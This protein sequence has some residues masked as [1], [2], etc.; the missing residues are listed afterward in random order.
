MSFR[1]SQ[2]SK[3]FGLGLRTEHYQDFLS[4]PQPVDWLE[5]ISDN[6]LVAG[7]KPLV[8]LDQLRR[9]YPMVM[10]GVAMSIGA[11]K[12]LD[13]D[14]LTR[15][16]RLAQRVEPLWI[17]DHLCWIGPGPEQLHDL[18]PLPYTDEAARRVIDHIRQVQDLLGRRFVLENVSSYIDYKASVQSEWQFLSHVAQEADCLLLLDVNNVYVSS[19]NHGFDPME[20]LRALPAGRI[21]QIHLAGHSPAKGPGHPV[22]DTHDHPVAPEVWALFEQARL[23]FGPVATMIERDA[24]IP[25]LDVLLDELTLAR[26]HARKADALV[27]EQDLSDGRLAEAS[28]ATADSDLTLQT[29]Q[30]RISHYVLSPASEVEQGEVQTLLRTPDGMDP[31]HRI[32]AYHHAYRARLTEV[33]ADTFAKTY[34]F[35]GSD[36]FDAE[37]MRFAPLNPPLQRSLNRYGEGFPDYLAARY[38]GHPELIELA[39]L[40]W[41]LRCTFDGANQAPLSAQGAQEDS[42]MAWLHRSAPL[43]HSVSMRPITTNVISI[44]HAIDSMSKVTSTCGIPRGAG[45][46]PVSWNLPMVR[47]SCAIWRSPWSTW[48]STVVWL[49]SAVLKTSDFLV[50]MVVLRGMSTVVTPPSVSMPSES[51]VTSS[52]STSFTSP[53]STPP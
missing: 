29:I 11:A 12:G 42:E 41:D 36:L 6:Y 9:D 30:Q 50:G 39:L 45:G 15:L 3:G 51:G 8:V 25:P 1:I 7:G 53:P 18:Y 49:S 47:L 44:W 40:D 38:P 14:Y 26:E 31:S 22:I 2:Q 43:H 10:H 28:S 37:A 20:Y 46:I 4:Q 34:L 17:S 35:M 32:G 13:K 33:L 23:L 48:I 27:G 52:R 21:Q 19:V 24:N 5:V 16:K